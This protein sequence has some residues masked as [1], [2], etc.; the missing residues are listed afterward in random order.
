MFPLERHGTPDVYKT[1][2]EK[3]SKKRSFLPARVQERVV[4]N[5]PQCLDTGEQGSP[6]CR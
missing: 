2:A 6:G 3:F 5:E 1:E 4:Q